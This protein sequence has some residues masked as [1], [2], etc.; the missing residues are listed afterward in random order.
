MVE[1]LF[2]RDNITSKLKFEQLNKIIESLKVVKNWILSNI[3]GHPKT[4]SVSCKLGK[5]V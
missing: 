2:D 3:L 1:S 5:R 4:E